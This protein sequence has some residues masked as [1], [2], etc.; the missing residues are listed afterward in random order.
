MGGRPLVRPGFLVSRRSHCRLDAPW[1]WAGYHR[2]P[3]DPSYAFALLQDPGLSSRT[4]PLAVLPTPPPVGPDRRHPRAHYIEAKHRAL[5][6]A[7]YASRATSP[8][9][10][11]DSLPA[12]GLSPL[13]GGGRTL[14]IASKGFRSHPSSFPGL[15]PVA[16]SVNAAGGQEATCNQAEISDG[17]RTCVLER[18]P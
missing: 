1:A 2:F 4:S 6:S 16:R 5:A 15:Y 18:P 10:V 13:P 14:W 8:P 17:S 11:Q 3:G 9:L 7:V 12:G